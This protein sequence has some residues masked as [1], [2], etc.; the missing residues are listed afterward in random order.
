[1]CFKCGELICVGNQDKH[2]SSKFKSE[3]I[4]S[5]AIDHI[6]KCSGGSGILLDTFKGDVILYTRGRQVGMFL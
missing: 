2:L 1:M 4:H 5:P 6:I 3:I